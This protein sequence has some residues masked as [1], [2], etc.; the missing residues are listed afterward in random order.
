MSG[1]RLYCQGACASCSELGRLLAGGA[2]GVEILDVTTDPAAYQAVLELG[3]RSLPVLHTPA[4]RSAAGSAAIELARQLLGEAAPAAAGHSHDLEATATDP[5]QPGPARPPPHPE[6]TPLASLLGDWEGAGHGSYPSIADFDYTETLSFTHT[7]KPF[8]VYTQRT[9]HLA[10]GR[11][12]HLETGYLRPAGPG[13]AELVVVQP[14]GIVEVDEGTLETTGGGIE[15]RL[16][17]RTVAV[18]ST[19]KSVTGVE[20]TVS[21]DAGALRTRLAMAAVG[22]PLT[23]HLASELHKAYPKATEKEDRR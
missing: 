1:V 17:S 14:T 15:L 9:R 3:Y 23:H 4:G 2:K 7:G 21:L 10:D 22:Y 18:T 16:A 12:L 5:D 13:H 6:I 20:R 11:P 8:L 19:A